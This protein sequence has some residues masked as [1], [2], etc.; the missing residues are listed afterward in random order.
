MTHPLRT[1]LA[2]I[3]LVLCGLSAGLCVVSYV[4]PVGIKDRHNWYDAHG[5][6]W[7]LSWTSFAVTQGRVYWNRIGFAVQGPWPQVSD[8]PDRMIGK[9][10]AQYLE[11][12][13]WMPYKHSIKSSSGGT[14]TMT[15]WTLS[16]L[17]M[18]PL[19]AILPIRWA[20][21]RRWERRRNAAKMCVRCG[22]DLRASSGRCPE[23]GEAIPRMSL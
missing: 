19:F 22:Y 23:C 20:V 4:V 7:G 10:V 2:A 12:Q 6:L 15:Q 13:T 21:L 11:V 1:T 17:L 8:S 5:D 9:G 3:S 16:V 18:W 14:F